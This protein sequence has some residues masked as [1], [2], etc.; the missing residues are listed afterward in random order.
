[1]P[2]I[3]KPNGYISQHFGENGNS[4]YKDHGLLGHPATDIVNGYGSDVLSLMRGK[5]YKVFKTPNLT[6]DNAQAVFTLCQD[7]DGNWYEIVY[8]HLSEVEINEGDT[9]Y[10][11]E[12]VGKEGNSGTVYS[13]GVLVTEEQKRA[14]S[15]AGH[16]VHYQKR[17]VFRC[18]PGNG[19]FYEYLTTRDG[20]FY[21]D[22]DGYTYKITNYQNGYNGCTDMEPDFYIP[23]PIQQ[24]GFFTK[25]VEFFKSKFSTI[26]A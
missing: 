2:K 4:W 21:K 16:H 22:A 17:P 5:A 8:F 20:N 1:M 12:M 25:L 15:Q 11:Y 14:G 10:E 9:V 18:A 19:N 3:I 24:I 6:S 23:T 13:G 26:H 7:I